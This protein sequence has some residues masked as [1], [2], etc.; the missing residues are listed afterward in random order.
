MPATAIRILFI[1]AMLL[2]VWITPYQ[3]QACSCIMTTYLAEWERANAVFLGTVVDIQ[4]PPASDIVSSADPLTYTFRTFH[5]WKGQPRL[6]Y[7][8]QSARETMS[9]GAVFEQDETY[10]VYAFGQGDVLSTY[11]CTTNHP[12]SYTWV[13]RYD[14]FVGVQKIR[15]GLGFTPLTYQDFLA[16]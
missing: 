12:A 1:L 4:S 11:L 15:A 2:M 7:Q 10:V 14:L 5:V 9:C 16:R 13:Y 3:A 6:Q 8:V